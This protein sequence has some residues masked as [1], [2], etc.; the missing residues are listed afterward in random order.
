M[1]ENKKVVFSGVQPSGN[2][3][4][5]NYLGAIKN[6]A[7]HFDGVCAYA[8]VPPQSGDLGRTYAI[9]LNQCILRNTFFFHYVPQIVVRNHNIQAS[10]SS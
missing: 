3:T 10:L 4:I 7:K 8:F 5:G 6:F 1:A 9:L 2:L